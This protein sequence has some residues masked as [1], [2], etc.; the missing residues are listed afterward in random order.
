MRNWSVDTSRLR[1][2][3]K[4]Y[5][6]WKLEQQLNFGLAKNE[7]INKKALKKYL[8]VLNID[9][10]TRNFIEYILYEKKPSFPSAKKL[11]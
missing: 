2:N 11:S 8:P 5:S 9:A 3:P 7:K 4:K 1:K 6:V 10:D